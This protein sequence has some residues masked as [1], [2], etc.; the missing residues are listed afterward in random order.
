MNNDH[1]RYIYWKGGKAEQKAE[2]FTSERMILADVVLNR[3]KLLG[4]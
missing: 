1:H 2:F 3:L 4:S